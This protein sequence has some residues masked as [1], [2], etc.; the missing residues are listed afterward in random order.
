MH[1]HRREE[2]LDEMIA[3]NYRVDKEDKEIRARTTMDNLGRFLPQ[4]SSSVLAYLGYACKNP[5]WLEGA[6]S[7]WVW[8]G[9]R[10]EEDLRIIPKR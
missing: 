10:V 4:C 5:L 1:F 2:I 3:Y 7:R 9:S 8:M 6:C